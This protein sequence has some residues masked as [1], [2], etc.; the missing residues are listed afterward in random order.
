MFTTRAM[1]EAINTQIAAASGFAV[2]PRY[3]ALNRLATIS[4]L[5]HVASPKFA[6]VC[7]AH[8]VPLITLPGYGRFSPPKLGV[9][10]VRH[11]QETSHHRHHS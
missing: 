6:N 1:I 3:V 10:Q 2:I 8:F 7:A 4:V 5:D 9:W 11:S